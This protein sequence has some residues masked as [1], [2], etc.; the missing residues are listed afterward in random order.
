ML[1]NRHAAELTQRLAAE[2]LTPGRAAQPLGEVVTAFR[3]EAVR[4]GLIAALSVTAYGD[5]DWRL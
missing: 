2:L 1:L 5:S 4:S 3:R